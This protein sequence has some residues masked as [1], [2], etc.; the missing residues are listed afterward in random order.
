MP[1]GPAYE[2]PVSWQVISIVLAIIEDT[3]TLVLG[4]GS[5]GCTYLHWN[6]GATAFSTLHPLLIFID[7]IGIVV[8]YGTQDDLFLYY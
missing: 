3:C 6:T 2:P 5:A 4:T 8:S 7:G 1:H